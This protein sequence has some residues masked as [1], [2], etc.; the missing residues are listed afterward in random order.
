MKRIALLLSL[1]AVSAV[2]AFAQDNT[3][4]IRGTIVSLEGNVLTVATAGENRRLTLTDGF[5]V[6]AVVKADITRIVPGIYVGSAA[7]TQPDG[8]LRAQEVHIFPEAM[9]GTGEGHRPYDLGPQ[10][11]MTNGTVDTTALVESVGDHVLTLKYKDGEKKVFVSK[12]TPIVAY[13]AADAKMLVPGAH[14]YIIAQRGPD[15][16]LSTARVNVGKNGLVPPM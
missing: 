2:P 5:H 4:R 9:R 14:V 16:A 1:L 8:T 11:T 3:T 6:I 7:V 15:G 13:E 12:D 10:S